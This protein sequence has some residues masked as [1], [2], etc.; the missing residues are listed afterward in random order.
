[1]G[2]TPPHNRKRR[3]PPASGRKKIKFEGGLEN[4]IQNSVEHW[5]KDALPYGKMAEFFRSGR[6]RFAPGKMR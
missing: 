3:I 4:D 2:G 5:N 1:M 6:N